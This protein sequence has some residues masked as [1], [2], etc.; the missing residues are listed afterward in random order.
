MDSNEFAPVFKELCGAFGKDVT[1]SGMTAMGKDFLKR[2]ERLS[3]EQWVDLCEAAKDACDNFPSR[4]K[5]CE[6]AASKGL[7]ESARDQD[8]NRPP[9]LTP[10]ECTCGRSF[11]LRQEDMQSFKTFDCPGKTYNA[12]NKSFAAEYLRDCRRASNGVI[13]INEQPQQETKYPSFLKD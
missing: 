10:V 11:V 6:L 12:C 8:P 9:A 5:L 1:S 7:F 2:F 3:F 13:W 4:K